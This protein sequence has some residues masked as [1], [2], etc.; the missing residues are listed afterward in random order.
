L[1]SPPLASTPIVELDCGKVMQ[2]VS[3]LPLGEGPGVRAESSGQWLVVSG[4]FSER[5]GRGAGGE[6]VFS[7]MPDFNAPTPVHGRFRRRRY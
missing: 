4:Q 3:P 1:S 2:A 6:G 5:V 7:P